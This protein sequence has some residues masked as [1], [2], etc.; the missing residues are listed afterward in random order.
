MI[1]HS[2]G[3][4]LALFA[5][6]EGVPINAPVPLR[7]HRSASVKA[8]PS[9]DL[10]ERLQSLIDEGHADEAVVLFQREAWV[11]RTQ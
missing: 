1:G 9:T 6:A 10:P 11:C 4:I 7:S 2:S 5:A 3:A 8:S